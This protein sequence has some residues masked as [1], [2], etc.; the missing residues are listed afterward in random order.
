MVPEIPLPTLPP[1][2]AELPKDRPVHVICQRGGRGAQATSLLRDLGHDAHSVSGGT[3]A[4]RD[5]GRPT[6]TGDVPGTPVILEEK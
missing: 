5:A 2:L 6:V 1:A 3:A 4:W